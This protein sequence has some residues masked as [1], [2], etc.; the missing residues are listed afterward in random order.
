MDEQNQKGSTEDTKL[1]SDN[2]E[3]V[4]PSN[5]PVT[6]QETP[7]VEPAPVDSQVDEELPALE[8]GPEDDDIEWTSSEFVSSDKGILWYLYLAIITIAI[9]VFAYLIMHDIVAVVSLGIIALIFGY[10]GKRKPRTMSYR[11]SNDGVF[12]S[13]KLYLYSDFKS[14]GILREGAFSSLV[15]APSKRF[16][17]PLSIYYPPEQEKV[18]TDQIGKYLPFAPVR[19]DLLDS[20]MRKVGL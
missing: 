19:T 16:M 13:E 12:V 18:I 15:L 17:P 1:D 14:F 2:Q 8:P 4:T 11:I 10:L 9:M 7:E 20:A 3:H 5:L 6:E